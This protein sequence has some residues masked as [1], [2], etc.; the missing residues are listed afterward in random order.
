MSISCEPDL[1]MGMTTDKNGTNDCTR[2]IGAADNG[3]TS[4]SAVTRRRLTQR[5]WSAGGE[6]LAKDIDRRN[7]SSRIIPVHRSRRL[8]DVMPVLYQYSVRNQ[9]LLQP[10]GDYLLS[11]WLKL[12]RDDGTKPTY[13]SGWSAMVTSGDLYDSHNNIKVSVKSSH[14][15]Y[16]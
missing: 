8:W 12:A 5:A 2:V 1:V 14:Q 9:L 16:V 15:I 13:R 3:R 6:R 4:S 11:L 10:F 7:N